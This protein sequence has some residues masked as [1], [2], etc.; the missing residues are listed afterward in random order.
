M[1]IYNATLHVGLTFGPLLGIVALKLSF[2]D[3][4][5]VFFSVV[6]AISA[7]IIYFT[8]ENPNE[9]AGVGQV[10]FKNVTALLGDK[11]ILAT[12]AGITLYGAG[13]GVC[14]TNI[15]AYLSSVK[16]YGQ[17]YI[18]IFFACYYVSM[19][20]S[21]LSI[22]P[23]SDK[24]GREKFMLFGVLASGVTMSAFPHFGREISLVLLTIGGLGLGAF[25]VASM[26]FLNAA[27]PD[28]L[29][30]TISGAY[31]LF[32]GV[33]YLAGPV[34]VG[35]LGVMPGNNYGFYAYSVSLFVMTAIFASLFKGASRLC[36]SRRQ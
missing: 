2:G 12:L 4:A 3:M 35:R 9:T 17:T 36:P 13:Y 22:G 19:S 23:L 10:D 7:A 15:P 34:I 5:Y 30:G 29:K 21:Q 8:V 20:V 27:V 14:L 28:S 11:K 16:G 33:G 18:Q 31:Y 6:C 26:A 1:G 25:C 32:W 24:F